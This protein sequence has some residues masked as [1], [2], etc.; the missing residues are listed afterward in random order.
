MRIVLLI[1][2]SPLQI[3]C[4]NYLYKK[5]SLDFVIFEEGESFGI[6]KKKV[7]VKELLKKI[8]LRLPEFLTKTLLFSQYIGYLINRKKYFG[9]QDHYNKTILG[10]DYEALSN[11]LSSVTVPNINSEKVRDILQAYNPDIVLVFGTRLINS[12]I[13]ESCKAKFVNMHWGWSPNY[14]GEGIVSALAVE[15][16]SALGVTVHFISSKIDGGDILYRARPQINATDNFYSIGVKLTV[17]GTD[18]FL[19]VVERFNEDN[20]F[21]E[22]QDLNKGFLYDSKYMRSHL[23]YYSKAWKRLKGDI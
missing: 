9:S 7:N 22:P 14:R 21:G 13:F 20:I 3:Y 1:R 12:L 16:I 18:L 23:D 4:A 17:I 2:K 10:G 5:K 6:Y 19:K 8:K 11:N 15:G